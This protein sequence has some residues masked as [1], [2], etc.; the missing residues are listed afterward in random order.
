MGAW[1]LINDRWYYTF[2]A[3]PKAAKS[4]AYHALDVAPFGAKDELSSYKPGN[5]PLKYPLSLKYTR[6]HFAV[7]VTLKIEYFD[8]PT[9][10][11]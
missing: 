8:C 5:Y 7:R 4:Q 10:D 11:G 1:V 2:L 9:S 6:A 3:T